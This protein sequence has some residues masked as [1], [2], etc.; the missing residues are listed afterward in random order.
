MIRPLRQRHRR[1]FAA[2]GVLLPLA[3]A[4]GIAARKPVPS[5]ASLPK[6]LAASQ[7][8]FTATRW[9]RR[10]LFGKSPIRVRLLRGEGADHIAIALS[11]DKDFVKPD[12]I[13]YWVTGNPTVADKLP[14]SATLLGAFTATTLVLPANAANE[15]G[16]LILFSLANQEIVDVS[17]PTRFND[18][19]K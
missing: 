3:F 2:L 5:V 7:D 16:S 14:E 9:E 19:T 11:A 8:K 4:V 17:K 1:M 6:G 18:S 13:V 15:N 12:L 10:D